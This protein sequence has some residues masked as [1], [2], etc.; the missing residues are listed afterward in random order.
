MFLTKLSKLFGKKKENQKTINK[1]HFT[2]AATEYMKQCSFEKTLFSNYGV[3]V[4][5]QRVIPEQKHENYEIIDLKLY[6]EIP[7]VIEPLYRLK[8]R[9][10]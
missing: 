8:V 6:H 9:E 5:E 10:F 1:Y 4:Y 2:S 7:R 3:K